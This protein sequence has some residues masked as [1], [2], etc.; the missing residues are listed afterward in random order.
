MHRPKRW[1]IAPPH[2]QAADLAGKLR[3]SPVIAQILLNR[4]IAEAEEKNLDKWMPDDLM[5]MAQRN[6]KNN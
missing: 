6:V 1:I 4:G 5:A 3:T 2:A